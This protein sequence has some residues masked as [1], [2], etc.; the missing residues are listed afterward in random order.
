MIPILLDPSLVRIG[1]IG[2]GPLSLRRL[3]WLH[4][5][6][7]RPQVFAPHPSAEMAVEAGADLIRRLPDEREI[8]ALRV[9]WIADID[10]DAAQ[11][12]AA[13]GR[14]AGALVNVEDVLPFCDFHTPSVVRRGRLTLAAG[15]GGASPATAGLV[16]ERLAAAFPEPWAEALETVAAARDALRAAGATPL[17]IAADARTRLVA[18]GLVETPLPK[19]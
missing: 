15:T 14:A 12:L 9:V 18:L 16:R 3:R 17:E 7:A 6:G 1:L 19:A 8:A 4:A 13:Q 5:G 2:D 11:A 10:A